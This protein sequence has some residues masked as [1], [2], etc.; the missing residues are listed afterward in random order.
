MT[1]KEKIETLKAIAAGKAGIEDLND[2]TIIQLWRPAAEPGYMETFNCTHSRMISN[3][4]FAAEQA[5]TTAMK[6]TLNI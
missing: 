3:E 4:K 1:R 2:E 5:A 6:I